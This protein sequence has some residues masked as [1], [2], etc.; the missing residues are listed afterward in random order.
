MNDM[1]KG[2]FR[3]FSRERHKLPN[4]N[5]RYTQT[6]CN[7]QVHAPPDNVRNRGGEVENEILF[8]KWHIIHRTTSLWKVAGFS[9]LHYSYGP[10][11]GYFLFDPGRNG[12][13]IRILQERS[14]K[15]ENTPSIANPSR[16]IGRVCG[17]NSVS[18]L[19][20]IK[21]QVAETLPCHMNAKFYTMSNLTGIEL[22]NH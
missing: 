22:K 3:I 7:N 6:S 11:I 19:E 15:T 13:F 8:E 2:H 20:P 4:R 1:H 21:Y 17:R 14:F 9:L 12:P 16:C 5:A 10:D 18:I